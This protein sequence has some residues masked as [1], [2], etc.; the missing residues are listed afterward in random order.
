MVYNLVQPTRVKQICIPTYLVCSSEACPGFISAPVVV[1]SVGYLYVIAEA[2][3]DLGLPQFLHRGPLAELRKRKSAT[4]IPADTLHRYAPG[5]TDTPNH[6]SR[7]RDPE[8]AANL[9]STLDTNS[10]YHLVSLSPSNDCFIFSKQQ[11]N[12][13]C[14]QTRL[15]WF[16]I[17]DSRFFSPTSID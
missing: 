1:L 14:L 11:K 10:R 13:F 4:I 7:T 8:R 6:E 5:N 16:V 3:Q 12:L 17:R 15:T 2:D 9:L